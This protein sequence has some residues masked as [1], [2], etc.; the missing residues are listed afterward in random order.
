V[1]VADSGGGIPSEVLPRVF[2]PFVTSKATGMGLGLAISRTIV[3]AY[4]GWIR[5]ENLPSGG[6]LFQF[7]I[8]FA[9]G[10]HA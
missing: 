6:A 8:P 4:G 5:A 10:Q 1:S 9:A 3:E 7:T 2:D